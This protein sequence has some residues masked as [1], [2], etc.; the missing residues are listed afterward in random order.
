DDLPWQMLWLDGVAFE[1]RSWSLLIDALNRSPLSVNFHEQFRV[2]CM[3]LGDDWD[4]YRSRWSKSHRRSMTKATKRLADRGKVGFRLDE[5]IP[6]QRLDQRLNQAFEVEDNSW[7]GEAGT[8]IL[9][10]DSM[11]DFFAGQANLLNEHGHLGLAWLTVDDQPVA[12]EYAMLSKGVYH[13][14][15]VSYEAAFAQASPGQ[16]LVMHLL[17]HFHERADVHRFDCMGPISDSITRWKPRTYPVGRLVIATQ[18]PLAK[19]LFFGYEKI[20]PQVRRLR[21]SN[22]DSVQVATNC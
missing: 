17:E 6:T 20:W 7:K 11:P 4:D 22:V 21:T 9:R 2:G 19:A 16:L 12:F 5:D 8:S 1:N 14:F 13:S 10:T 15:K 3:E 18:R